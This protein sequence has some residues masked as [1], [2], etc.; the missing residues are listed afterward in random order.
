MYYQLKGRASLGLLRRA[1]H[2]YFAWEP[3]PNAKLLKKQARMAPRSFVRTT[4]AKR[5]R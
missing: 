2:P 4:P 5:G 3:E 1:R